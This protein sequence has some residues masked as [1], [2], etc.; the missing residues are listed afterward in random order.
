MT[1]DPFLGIAL[2]ATAVALLRHYD[3]VTTVRTYWANI[4]TYIN[5]L[6]ETGESN[7][8]RMVHRY[9]WHS[10]TSTLLFFLSLIVMN[11]LSLSLFSLPSSHFVGLSVLQLW[12]LGSAA[13]IPT[14]QFEFGECVFSHQNTHLWSGVGSRCGGRDDGCELVE[15][16]PSPPGD[17]SFVFLQ[18]R[19]R[20][21]L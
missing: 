5:W 4:R 17:V 7:L 8:C 6:R 2:P 1:S 13:A 16:N 21:V 14:D 10:H 12:R 20:Y 18:L 3:D 11:T 9:E 19:N 15:I